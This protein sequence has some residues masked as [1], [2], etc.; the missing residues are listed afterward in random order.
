MLTRPRL[1]WRARSLTCRADSYFTSLAAA[2]EAVDAEAVLVTANL[3]GHVPLALEALRA[4]KHVL[5][6]KPF[7]PS[8]DEAR[9]VVE[10]AE[11][12]I[13]CS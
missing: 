13:A 1:R 9:K 7:A 11:E 10:L 3:P 12:R 5:L 6:E 8:L 2:I 4:G